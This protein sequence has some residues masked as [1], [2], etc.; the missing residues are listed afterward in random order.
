[1]QVAATE[2]GWPEFRPGGVERQ[3]GSVRG[4]AA[5]FMGL[6][7]QRMKLDAK[8]IEAVFRI[9]HDNAPENSTLRRLTQVELGK[10]K[11]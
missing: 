4:P 7:Y 9:A 2:T 1:M 11:R 3:A 5:Y 10:R 6:R 8:Q